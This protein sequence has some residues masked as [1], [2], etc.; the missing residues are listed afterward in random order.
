MDIDNDLMRKI[1]KVGRNIG[2]SLSQSRESSIPMSVEDTVSL[3][4]AYL[5]IIN[6]NDTNKC[7]K[8]FDHMSKIVAASFIGNS[9][10]EL[11]SE[12]LSI[13]FNSNRKLLFFEKSTVLTGRSPI[14]DIV[15]NR[16]DRSI[17]RVA[18]VFVCIQEI[19]KIIVIDPG[20]ITGFETVS[21]SFEPE[22]EDLPCST[23]E[24]RR[25]G[26]FNINESFVVRLTMTDHIIAYNPKECV[27]CVDNPREHLL[28]CN[29]YVMCNACTSSLSPKLCPICRVP[30]SFSSFNAEPVIYY[31]SFPVHS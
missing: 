31:S 11:L 14:C 1:I 3:R 4:D 7:V 25:I 8:Y 21:R 27:I 17:S 13:S 5:N 28:P 16:Q 29:H 18:L 2:T 26:I 6:S 19:G 30:F 24:C 20:S 22:K 23:L 10:S 12:K 15:M 9:D